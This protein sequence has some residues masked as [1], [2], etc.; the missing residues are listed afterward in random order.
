MKKDIAKIIVKKYKDGGEAKVKDYEKDYEEDLKK[1][2]KGMS[3]KGKDFLKKI[4]SK[5][6]DK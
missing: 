2:V 3:Y 6:K 1:E 4:L 5:I